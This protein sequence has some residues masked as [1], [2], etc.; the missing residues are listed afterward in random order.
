MQHDRITFDLHFYL[1]STWQV[2]K[3]ALTI[4]FKKKV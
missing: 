4:L 3:K 2:K 1:I